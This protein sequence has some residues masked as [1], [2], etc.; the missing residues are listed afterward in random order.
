M[1]SLVRLSSSV[2]MVSELEV[3]T[4]EYNTLSRLTSCEAILNNISCESLKFYIKIACPLKRMVTDPPKTKEKP[5]NFPLT[6]AIY[7]K[8][9]LV[10]VKMYSNTNKKL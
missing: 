6:F 8:F 2:N 1:T 5:D 10:S 4:S 9:L 3:E 7:T